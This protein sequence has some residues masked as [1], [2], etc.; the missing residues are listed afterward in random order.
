[1]FGALNRFISRLDSDSQT[2][3]SKT[4]RDAAGFHVLK[5]TNQEL[6]IEPWFDFIVGINGR[7]IDNPD[8]NLFATEVRNC[9]G[10]TIS[11][12]I[13]S[14][15]GQRIREVYA[16]I[17]ADP[18]NLGL[19]L[20]W[21][22]LTATEDVWHILDVSP[23]SPADLAGLLPYGDYVIGSPE[24]TVKGESGLV[25]LIEEFV[26][27]PLRLYVYNHEYDVLRP[28]TITP[29]RS[30]GGSGLLGCVLGFG[31]LHRIPAP[32]NEPP[33][34]PGETMFEAARLSN[35]DGRPGSGISEK[36]V[37]SP[38]TTALSEYSSNFVV[39]ANA[40]YNS[41]SPPP[42]LGGAP[43]QNIHHKSGRKA[44]APQ[45][46]V[47]SMD[48]YFKEGEAK[49]KELDGPSTSRASDGAVPPPPKAGGGNN[50]SRTSP[51]P[52]PDE[53]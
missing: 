40:Q 34:A 31:A 16:S 52:T 15:K 9:A 18:P 35:E 42:P 27:R 21:T 50:A 26:D 4:P 39:P 33:N 48:D 41:S 45:N 23:N 7:T 51:Q 1:M 19:S 2:H 13:Y 22:P 38:S 14:A 5:N 6:A 30:W 32:L 29:S 11:L 25:E 46:A 12:G 10:S 53:A 43:P 49:S 37:F 17:P 8:D 24:G 44:R 36:K 20:H 28:V 3:Q 47:L